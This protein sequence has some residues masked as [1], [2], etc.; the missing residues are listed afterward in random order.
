MPL[1]S[2]LILRNVHNVFGNYSI[3]LTF[4]SFENFILFSL[5]LILLFYFILFRINLILL[6][7]II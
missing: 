2:L 3:Q 4:F 1:Y 7:L 6:I 5:I